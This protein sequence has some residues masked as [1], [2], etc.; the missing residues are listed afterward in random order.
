MIAPPFRIVP[1]P[2]R[3]GALVLALSLA[4]LVLMGW[5]KWRARRGGRRVP[6]RV[7]LAVALAGGTPGVV[8]GMLLF[9]HKTRHVLF[10]W[11]LPVLMLL[12]AWLAGR[13]LRW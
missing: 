9:R 6:E 10:A 7:L 8:L 1:P 5:D 13:F 4:G 11:G 2:Y 3:L 12:Q